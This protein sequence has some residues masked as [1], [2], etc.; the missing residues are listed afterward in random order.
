MAT[1][2][3]ER[4][5][6]SY[7]NETMFLDNTY[8]DV[9]D[10]VC[11]DKN[12]SSSFGTCFNTMKDNYILVGDVKQL[13]PSS[14]ISI[15]DKQT[16]EEVVKT[17]DEY[18]TMFI[19]KY[20]KQNHILASLF[21]NTYR[22]IAG[23]RR[24]TLFLFPTYNTSSKGAEK[25]NNSIEKYYRWIF[26]LNDFERFY[27]SNLDSVDSS[28]N[29]PFTH[30]KPINQP[31][32][33]YP[34]NSFVFIPIFTDTPNETA[35]SFKQRIENVFEDII[36]GIRK[37][38]VGQGQVI[39]GG[40]D[41]FPY[42]SICYMIDNEKDKNLFTGYYTNTILSTDK[43][44]ILNE[45]LNNFIQK[46]SIDTQTLRVPDVTPDPIKKLN[47]DYVSKDLKSIAVKIGLSSGAIN[48]YIALLNVFIDKINETYKKTVD[49][50]YAKI[51]T[52][53]SNISFMRIYYR[54][55]NIDKEE[56]YEIKTGNDFL[57]RLTGVVLNN[58]DPDTTCNKVYICKLYKISGRQNRYNLEIHNQET[59]RFRELDKQFCYDN[60]QDSNDIKTKA[61]DDELEEDTTDNPSKYIQITIEIKKVFG[62]Y[63][64]KIVDSTQS[65]LYPG[66]LVFFRDL[67]TNERYK[68]F[69]HNDINGSLTQE[70][71]IKFYQNI[72]FDKKSLI[73]Y[74]KS[75]NTYDEKKPNLGTE[76]LKINEDIKLL[77][78]YSDFIYNSEQFKKTHINEPNLLL[79]SLPFN[80]NIFLE[81]IKNSILDII[82]QPNQLIYVGGAKKSSSDKEDTSKN[83]K[84]IGY[85]QYKTDLNSIIN[86][87]FK[88]AKK[89]KIGKKTF[90]SIVDD[91]PNEII[92]TI[93]PLTYSHLNNI[94]HGDESEV[95]YC[96][97]RKL[98]KCEII[99]EQL[100][101]YEER[102]I[103][104]VDITRDEHDA[105]TL[106]QKA[107]CKRLRKTIRLRM[108]G[109]IEPIRFDKILLG[110]VIGGKKKKSVKRKTIK[111]KNINYNH[112]S[113]HYS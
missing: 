73:E 59:K 44:K 57:Y 39:I 23:E 99:R 66:T 62:I 43:K 28:A 36:N 30:L 56:T 83:Y 15:Q 38:V 41:K 103:A 105:S 88:K 19:K 21:G 97:H 102:V 107:K 77:I 3:I 27:L 48:D 25:L 52:A 26:K 34:N 89:M 98:T 54:V 95:R 9:K 61:D 13:L 60:I 49:K 112:Y 90:D 109:L 78:E 10:L 17:K 110:K 55:N 86:D 100:K 94:S 4:L 8:E 92:K 32:E 72:L 79:R 42:T 81:K 2:S 111:K 69:K 5:V 33:G 22:K 20:I 14:E 67:H 85:T 93:F 40:K 76:F 87:N 47:K 104:V 82:F 71:Q 16:Y 101:P 51:A 45:I 12:T 1:I 96:P 63:R 84:V 31:K 29:P 68:W 108:K 65:Y 70:T 53:Q 75:K 74:L 106:Q 37:E 18:K 113:N 35:D 11:E 46:K 64:F 6:S 50:A 58:N 7:N 24:N 91:T 80:Q